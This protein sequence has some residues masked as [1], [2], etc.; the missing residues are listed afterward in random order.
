MKLS[1][2]YKQYQPIFNL[3]YRF[4]PEDETFFTDDLKKFKHPE[5]KEDWKVAR[6][7]TKAYLNQRLDELGITDEMN[8][9]SLFDLENRRG[10]MDVFTANKDGDI[11]ILQYDLKRK[12]HTYIVSKT[13]AGTRFEYRVQRRLNPIYQFICEGKYDF[14]E[15]KNTPF[16]HPQLIELFEEQTPIDTLYITEGQFKAWKATQDGIPTVGLT[17]ISHFKDKEKSVLSIHPEIVEFIQTCKPKKV[18]ILWDADCKNVSSSDLDKGR[19]ATKRPWTFYNYARTIKSLLQNIFPA[20]RLQIYFATIKDDVTSEPKGIDDLLLV[21][22]IPVKEIVQDFERIGQIPGYYI[23]WINITNTQ[24]EKALRNYFNLD[25]VYHFYTAHKEQI[26][27]K[28]FIYNGNTY[29]IEKDAPIMEVSADLKE[30]KLIGTDWFRETMCIV[31][32]GKKGDSV[33]EKRLIGW[34]AD[35]IKLNHGKDALSKVEKYKGFTNFPSHV[36]YQPV[37][38]EEWN[39]YVDV[40]HETEE[41]E[42]PTIRKHL[43]HVFKEHYDNE[44]ILDYITVLYKNPMQKLPIICLLS[45]QQGTGKSTF[46]FLLKLIFKQNM[47]IISNADITNEFNSYWTSKLIAACEETIFDKKDAYEKLKAYTTQKF[48][49]RNEKNKSQT[50]IP[51]MLHFVLCSNHE[52]DFMKISKYDRRLWVRKVDTFKSREADADITFD[53][54]L[55]KEIPAF[56]NFIQN[57]DLKYKERGELFF[58]QTDFQTTAFHNLV[59]NSESSVVKEIKEAMIDSFLRYGGETR[60]VTAQD[61]KQYFGIQ[62]KFENT[63][64]NKILANEFDAVRLSGSTSSDAVRRYS[65]MVDS[66]NEPE[67]G[68]R[69]SKVGRPYELHRNWFLPN[70][71]K[72][73]KE[74]YVQTRIDDED[75]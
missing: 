26:K 15:A 55:E 34:K 53:D 61:L 18:V 42:F 2:E 32:T 19:E 39:L 21:K 38:N 4:N 10:M 59:T 3:G 73:V 22:E 51:C 9:C 6:I 68:E 30:Y 65:F 1:E 8:K 7:D 44:M 58:H 11:E 36:D 33:L 31:P 64:L 56:I 24:G 75:N 57:R 46:L 23:D 69:I 54:R 62:A 71:K 28:S 40:Q 5:G 25:S 52:D 43:Q 74:K 67:K 17:S 63:Y 47:A 20:K 48:L 45:K 27:E 37:I 49:V 13:S 66:F 72:V 12:P 14:S 60:E 50:E 29:R 41:G 16:W 70:E 35:I